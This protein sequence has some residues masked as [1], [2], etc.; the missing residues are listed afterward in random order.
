M[1]EFNQPFIQN[2]YR[3]FLWLTP[4]QTPEYLVSFLMEKL[5]RP[6]ALVTL[7]E[8]LQLHFD[9]GAPLVSAAIMI[10]TWPLQGDIQF[11]E[12]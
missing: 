2:V 1:F 7:S 3:A 8:K 10:Q 11:E 4:N 9:L 12:R 6:S 5:Q